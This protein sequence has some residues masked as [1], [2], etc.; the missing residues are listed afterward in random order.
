VPG[1]NFE[2]RSASSRNDGSIRF[3]L[4]DFYSGNEIVLQPANAADSNNKISISNPFSDRFSTAAFPLFNLPEKWKD[5]LLYRSINA[6]ADN[7]YLVE[8]KRQA[9]TM[10]AID[11][12]VFYGKTEKQYYLDDYTRFITMD[13]VMREFVV[14][15]R[16]RKQAEGY[17][18]RVVN[19]AYKSLFDQDPLVL[20]D[21]IP[22]SRLDKIMAL[23]PLKIKRID[24]ATHRHYLGPLT[25]D[26]IV[27][28]RTYE[29]DLGGYELDPS[30]VVIAYEGLQRQREFYAPVYETAAQKES[31]VPDLR[32]VLYWLPNV[33]TAEGGKQQVSFYA[34]DIK[35]N[36]AVIVQ[37]LTATGLCGSAVTTFAVK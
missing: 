22:V 19:G 37:G 36:F 32:N 11:T 29:G 8:K 10:P 33:K 28:Y 27:S 13:E 4:N 35:A 3:N 31:R 12:N 15:V 18:F 1:E 21:G 30:S 2:L 16:V 9:F 5:Q 25:S 17:Q 6:Q 26:G 24:V 14:D 23:D 20:I 34:S 7:A